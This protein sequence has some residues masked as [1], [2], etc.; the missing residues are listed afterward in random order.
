MLANIFA[1]HSGP[2]HTQR[3]WT[4]GKISAVHIPPV[5]NGRA[6]EL[7]QVPSTRRHV[8][9]AVRLPAIATVDRRRRAGAGHTVA[10][11]TKWE[12]AHSPDCYRPTGRFP[13]LLTALSHF[14]D[15][16]A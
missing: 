1:I 16:S 6:W 14:L 7:A 4:D 2:L 12:L 10:Y 11:V 8:Q 15:L 9:N 13:P 3:F 5:D